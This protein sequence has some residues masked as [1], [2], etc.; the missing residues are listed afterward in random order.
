M[1]SPESCKVDSTGVLII[2]VSLTQNLEAER[3]SSQVTWGLN[4]GL[5]FPS[6]ARFLCSQKRFVLE[7]HPDLSH[8]DYIHRQGQALPFSLSPSSLTLQP[9]KIL[10]AKVSGTGCIPH[11]RTACVHPKEWWACKHPWRRDFSGP[12]LWNCTIVDNQWPGYEKNFLLARILENT[13]REVVGA[14]WESSMG[15][16]E[17]S[18]HE[19]INRTLWRTYPCLSRH[20]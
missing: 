10:Y 14:E 12:F 11:F 5:S 4:P 1:G 15:W 9:P 19:A 20:V 8:M 2:L 17:L 13:F 18:Y 16:H 3:V 6:A 7:S